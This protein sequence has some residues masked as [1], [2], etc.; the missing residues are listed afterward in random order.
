[1]LLYNDLY[2]LPIDT[3]HPI[4]MYDG[5]GFLLWEISTREFWI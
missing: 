1:M 2:I 3:Q 4:F 5:L